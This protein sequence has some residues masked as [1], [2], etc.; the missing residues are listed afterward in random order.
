MTYKT[1]AAHDE[2]SRSQPREKAKYALR[3][4]RADQTDFDHD[5]PLT[6]EFTS[7]AEMRNSDWRAKRDANGR[8]YKHIEGYRW[9]RGGWIRIAIFRGRA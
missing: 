2:A 6:V 1:G 4:W 3:F 7:E 5:E 9:S 8:R